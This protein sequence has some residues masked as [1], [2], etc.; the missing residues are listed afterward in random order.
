MKKIAIALALAA[1]ATLPGF[2][3]GCATR[4]GLV[5]AM[6]DGQLAG[7]PESQPT[8]RGETCE[9]VC[10]GNVELLNVGCVV[11]AV[12]VSDVRICNVRCRQ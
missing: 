11:Q 3:I 9:A 7:C 1:V 4:D 8:P 6:V 12:S 2:A 5:P 10:A